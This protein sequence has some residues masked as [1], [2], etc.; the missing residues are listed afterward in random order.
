M[1]QLLELE[2]CLWR[3][4]TNDIPSLVQLQTRQHLYHMSTKP[5]S[6]KCGYLDVWMDVSVGGWW[7]GGCVVG[8]KDRL[9]LVE[10]WMEGWVGKCIRHCYVCMYVCM[11]VCTY[12]CTHVR[13]YEY[14]YAC[15]YI[16]VRML[17]EYSSVGRQV[18]M[19]VYVFTSVQ[20]VKGNP[21][22]GRHGIMLQITFDH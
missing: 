20:S 10:K 1:L 9:V 3:K 8:W 5:S 4:L 18:C 11:Y 12:V 15:I 17:K 14:M 6:L 21:L 16:Y 13:M 19:Y 2:L 22:L 7:L